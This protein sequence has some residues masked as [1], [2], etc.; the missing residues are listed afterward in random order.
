MKDLPPISL[1]SCISNIAEDFVV[2][3]YVKPAALQVLDD[4]QFGASKSSTTLAL[5]EMLHT[6][7]EATDGNIHH[8]NNPFRLQKGF[9]LH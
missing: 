2:C 4:I 6:W 5:Q 8:Q 9:R 1:T 3:D 7:T